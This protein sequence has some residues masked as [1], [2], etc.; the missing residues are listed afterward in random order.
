MMKSSEHRDFK[1]TYRKRGD[2]LFFQVSGDVDSQAVRI[3][4]WQEIVAITKREGLRKLLVVDRK[5]H[6]PASPEQLAQLAGMMQIHSSI[7]DRIAVVDDFTVEAPKTKL[8]AQKIK[9]MG[10]ESVL[11][12][13]DGVDDNLYLASR[14]LINAAVVDV[15]HADP[16]SLVNFDKVLMTKAAVEKVKELFA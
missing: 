16:V 2:L 5:K 15:T 12:I 14:N 10:L 8:F 4:Y 1:L 6:K 9:G 3:A 7:A 11:L 13:T